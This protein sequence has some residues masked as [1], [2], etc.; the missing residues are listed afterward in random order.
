MATPEREYQKL[1]GKR[2]G[3]V[4]SSFVAPVTC[5]LWLGKDHLL[6]VYNERYSESYKRF[7]FQ[8]IQVLGLQ[9]TS[10]RMIINLINAAIAS[11]ARVIKSHGSLA[12]TA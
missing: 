10:R 2:R 6:H 1:T 3:R 7:Y 4:V 8:D 12:L 9:T 11:P 5:Q